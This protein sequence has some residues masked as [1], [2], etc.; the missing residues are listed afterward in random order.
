VA[1]TD[2]LAGNAHSGALVAKRA[3]NRVAGAVVRLAD[4]RAKPAAFGEARAARACVY[5]IG[6]VSGDVLK[7]E[8][9]VFAAILTPEATAACRGAIKL[10]TRRNLCTARAAGRTFTDRFCSSGPMDVDCRKAGTEFHP[11]FLLGDAIA[12][13]ELGAY[14]GGG[15]LCEPT[16]HSSSHFSKAASA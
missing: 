3:G 1:H 16:R 4:E 10:A 13:S 6:R 5:V 15:I 14:G 7:K 12:G 9:Q 2:R 8:L 11:A